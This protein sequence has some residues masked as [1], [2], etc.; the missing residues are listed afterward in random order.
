PLRPR[1][2]VARLGLASWSRARPHEGPGDQARD[3]FGRR[4]GVPHGVPAASR[5]S[6]TVASAMSPAG[7]PS[8]PAGRAPGATGAGPGED[9]D[10]TTAI[11]AS[12]VARVVE[13]VG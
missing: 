3:H 11:A 9:G 12:P 8:A 7:R 4:A 6:T 13:S 10:T 2:P 1:G 5:R